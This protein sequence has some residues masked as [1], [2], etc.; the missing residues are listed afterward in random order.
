MTQVAHMA[1]AIEDNELNQP[2]QEGLMEHI[3][4]AQRNSQSLFE[5]QSLGKCTVFRSHIA[6]Q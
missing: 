5:I 1:A 4:N 6:F 2:L 3:S